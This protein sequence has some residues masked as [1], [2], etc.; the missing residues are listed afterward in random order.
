MQPCTF[1]EQVEWEIVCACVRA[2]VCVCECVGVCVCVLLPLSL[3]VLMDRMRPTSR[4]IRHRL[5]IGTRGRAIARAV[6][7]E[8]PVCDRAH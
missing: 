2:R 8:V 3:Y 5:S 7:V 6:V 1:P 4:A